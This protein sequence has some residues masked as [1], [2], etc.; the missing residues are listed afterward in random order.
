ML[1]LKAQL[2][3]LEQLLHTFVNLNLVRPAKAMQLR[4]VNELAHGAIGLG[5]IESDLSL[6]ANGFYNQ[7]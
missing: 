3:P 1:I 5:G 4:D 6:K 2:V 7:L